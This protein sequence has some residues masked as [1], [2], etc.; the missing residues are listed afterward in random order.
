MTEKEIQYEIRKVISQYPNI[1]LWRNNVGSMTDKNGQMVTFG[2]CPGSSDLIG[3]ESVIVTPDMVGKTIA[4]FL[5]IEVKSE[6]GKASESQSKFLEMVQSLGGV[7]ILARSSEEVEKN[8][9]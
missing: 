5:A 8:L 9:K 3:L 1:R 4:R 7:G 2:L 6:K